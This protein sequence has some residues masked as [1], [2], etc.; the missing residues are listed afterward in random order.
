MKE[1]SLSRRGV[2]ALVRPQPLHATPHAVEI[3][4]GA[5]L[6]SG[7]SIG[8]I[9]LATDLIRFVWWPAQAPISFDVDVLAAR[10]QAALPGSD[11][12]PWRIRRYRAWAMT[13]FWNTGADEWMPIA[14][15]YRLPGQAQARQITPARRA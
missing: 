5:M 9:R 10:L 12:T 2:T 13:L 15:Y 8:A 11:W 3:N 1:E 4:S 7:A 6:A 14:D